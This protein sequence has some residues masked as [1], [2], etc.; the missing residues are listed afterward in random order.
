MKPDVFSVVSFDCSLPPRPLIF[1]S[2]RTSTFSWK[3][4]RVFLVKKSTQRTRNFK[5]VERKRRKDPTAQSTLYS[6]PQ[7][8]I[9]HG[10]T[11]IVLPKRY[12]QHT[13]NMSNHDRTGNPYVPR[14][15]R[16]GSALKPGGVE[17]TIN[18]VKI[19]LFLRHDMVSGA[20]RFLRNDMYSGEDPG[21]T[22]FCRGIISR[23]GR[24]NLERT[25]R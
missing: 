8:N 21:G 23:S 20:G 17:T 14:K 10:W 2:R 5:L 9:V 16:N 3:H 7:I 6:Q 22:S 19:G 1:P 12:R 13:G 25:I 24:E 11:L 4:T 18:G 15:P